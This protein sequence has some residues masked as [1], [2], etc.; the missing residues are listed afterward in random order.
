MSQE[1]WNV[2]VF[3]GLTMDLWYDVFE[4][5]LKTLRRK[6]QEYDANEDGTLNFD[7]FVTVTKR[8]FPV[9]A[10]K[11]SERELT[12]LYSSFAGDDGVI[13]ED[14]F[15]VAIQC[16][17]RKSVALAN[18]HASVSVEDKLKNLAAGVSDAGGGGL[19]QIKGYTAND[20]KA[21]LFSVNMRERTDG[22]KPSASK[23]ENG[24]TR[25]SMQARSGSR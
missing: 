8:L 24:L 7:E 21:P 20:P 14:E 12:E 19:E 17:F 2:D 18:I 15:F 9:L 13:S 23:P 10:R 4:E 1:K 3:V 25:F 22:G 16:L 5:E 6:F 11:S